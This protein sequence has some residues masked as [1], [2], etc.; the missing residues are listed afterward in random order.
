MVC[1]ITPAR[2]QGANAQPRL[3]KGSSKAETGVIKQ[4]A[5]LLDPIA[6]SNAVDLR[7]GQRNFADVLAI[8]GT[9]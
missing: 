3:L 9:G 6:D 4:L 2:Q 5:V 7:A 1:R 8:P